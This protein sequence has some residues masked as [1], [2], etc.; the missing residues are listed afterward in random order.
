MKWIK[1]YTDAHRGEV[2]IDFASAGWSRAEA[3]GA[4][5]LF[6]TYLALR[7]DGCS[8]PEFVID[9]KD[10]KQHLG[11]RRPKFD[12]FVQIIT[13]SERNVN[14]MWTECER[15]VNVK[16]NNNSVKIN[17]EFS[18]LMKIL[19]KDAL[20]SASRPATGPPQ[21]RLDKEEDKDKD[22]IKTKAKKPQRDFSE[23]LDFIYSDYPRKE[24]RGNGMKKAKREIKTEDDLKLLVIAGE[25][26][27]NFCE[28]ENREKKY[29]LMF[30]TFMSQW[31]DWIERKH[32]DN[33]PHD[34]SK[35]F[36]TEEPEDDPDANE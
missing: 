31:R 6:V 29:I 35:Y 7:W 33:E 3:Y 22:N 12:S 19:H 34:R 17:V 5:F 24:G 25:N 14:V 21:A 15:N 32:S 9:E 2:F 10:L 16:R 26:Y 11:L 27:K 18:K 23:E 13:Q 1:L 36:I 20:S 8:K 28:A 4:Y 30:S